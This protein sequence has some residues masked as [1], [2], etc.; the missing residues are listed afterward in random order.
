MTC[1]SARPL[2]PQKERIRVLVAESNR[3]ASQLMETV[4][5]KSRRR[6]EVQAITSGSSE[7]IKHLQTNETHVAV[8]SAELQDGPLAGYRV[9]EQLRGFNSK[10][11]PIILLNSVARE[12]L[13]DAFRF[14]VRGVF[15]R[16]HSICTLP[17]CISAV[18]NGQLWINNEQ[19]E[20]LLDLISRLRPLQVVKAGGIA[21]LT[22]RERE[23]V[24]LVAEGM[25][26][27][28]I[29]QNLKVTEHTV[30]NYVCRVFEKLGVSSRVELVLYAL[31]R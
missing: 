27:E 23:T 5:Q 31:S 28:E 19:I 2:A 24:Q 6:F 29:A 18:H 11:A 4:L 22:D 16:S 13:I 25:R 17:K 10:T 8:I 21:L 26:N 15:T 1:F 9:L 30:R 14:G 7:I 20:L 3:M 12:L